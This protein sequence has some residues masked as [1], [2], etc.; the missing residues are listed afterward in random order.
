MGRG[1]SQYERCGEVQGDYGTSHGTRNGLVIDHVVQSVKPDHP[2]GEQQDQ[3]RSSPKRATLC[4]LLPIAELPDIL[5][6]C[7]SRETPRRGRYAKDCRGG[8]ETRPCV[9]QLRYYDLAY[10]KYGMTCLPISLMESMIRVWDKLP[11]CT[12]HSTWSTPAS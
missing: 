7:G 9:R 2:G 4:E 6:F 12:K 10:L 3:E 5:T 8:F 1:Q 11:G